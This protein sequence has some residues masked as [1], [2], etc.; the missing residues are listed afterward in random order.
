MGMDFKPL[1][2][3]CEVKVDEESYS[4]TF[5]RFVAGPFERGF[6]TTIG[7]SLRRILLS[8]IPGAAIVAVK[9]EGKTHEFDVIE[10][11][12]EDIL[13]ILLNL[14]NIRLKLLGNRAEAILKLEVSGPRG[15]TSGPKIVTAADFHTNNAVEIVN[16]EQPIAT[17]SKGA[18]LVMECLVRSGRGYVSSQELKQEYPELTKFGTIVL[19]AAFSPITNVRYVVEATRYARRTDYDRLILEITTNGTVRPDEALSCAAKLLKD[20]MSYFISSEDEAAERAAE[21][22]EKEFEQSV[23]ELQEKLDKSIEELEL[24]VRSYNCLEHAG[25][26]TIRDLIQKSESEMLKYRNFGRKSLN[27]IKGILKEMGLRFNMEID[28]ETGLPVGIFPPE[29]LEALKK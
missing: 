24:S 13:D 28:K 21:E 12:K 18:Q 10:G 22:E 23:R 1:I 11:V 4:P 8:S 17:L 15:E 14:K 6:G 3:G 20:H 19:D 26:K 2:K 5:G 25:I 29:K 9:I 7:N 16:P 27:E